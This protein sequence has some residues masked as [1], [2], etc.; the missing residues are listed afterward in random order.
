MEKPN[1]NIKQFHTFLQTESD[2]GPKLH[3]KHKFILYYSTLYC[4]A[5][6]DVPNSKDYG[7]RTKI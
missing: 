7:S 3:L 1:K 5:H 2:T 4:M 6:K